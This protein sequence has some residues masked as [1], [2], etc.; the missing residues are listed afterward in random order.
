[1]I[2]NQVAGLFGTGAPPVPASSYESIA[3]ANGT[4][5]SGTITFSSIPSTYKH[6]QIRTFARTTAAEVNQNIGIRLNS[7]SG[8]NYTYHILYDDGAQN[9]IAAAATGLTYGLAGRVAGA[10]ATANVYGAGVTDILDYTSTSINK[11][12]RTNAGDDRNG[13]GLIIFE[14][15]LWL[16]TSAITNIQLLDNAGGYFTTDSVFALYGI[17]G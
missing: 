12:I 6:L 15:S 16:N 5:S 1:M 17:K 3:S 14:S 10:S 2:A 7:D 4:G 13:G 11:T 9:P 8:S